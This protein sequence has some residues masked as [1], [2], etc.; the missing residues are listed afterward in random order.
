MANSWECGHIRYY[1]NNYYYLQIIYPKDNTSH[2][3]DDAIINVDIYKNQT[4]GLR[5]TRFVYK[6][7]FQLH[8]G[9]LILYFNEEWLIADLV[10]LDYKEF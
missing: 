3:N 1:N 5:N 4:K 2:Y 10:L 6:Q 8:R 7:D 9:V